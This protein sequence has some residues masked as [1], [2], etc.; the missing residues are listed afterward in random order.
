MNQL[1]PRLLKKRAFAM[2]FFQKAT[3][4]HF[5]DVSAI[6]YINEQENLIQGFHGNKSMPDFYRSFQS[7]EHTKPYIENW[8]QSLLR[9]KQRKE[10]RRQERLLYTHDYQ[11]GDI[12]YASW[13]YDQTNI[14][15]YQVLEVK[16]NKTIK[17]CEIG[18]QRDCLSTV[19][20][21]CPVKDSFFG[22]PLVKRVS[23]G[24]YVK[25]NE[26][27][28]AHKASSSS[29]CCTPEHLKR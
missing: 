13:G 10:R 5:E 23:L 25:I 20:Q 2:R 19:Y 9:E 18:S 26:V 21:V 28:S 3:I 8:Y 16:S 15:F 7:L 22:E 14:N 17:L 4:M 27:I 12:L 1:A 24:G 6:V 29:Y 11:V